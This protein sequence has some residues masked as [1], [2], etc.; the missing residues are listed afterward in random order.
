MD[1]IAGIIA[2][3]ETSKYFL[4]FGGS[5]LE[6]TIVM[7]GT[8]VLWHMGAVDFWPAY[9]ALMLGDILSDTCWYVLG[10]FAARPFLDRWGYLVG[11]P[12]E[13]MARVEKRFTLYQTPILI[14]SKL[15]MG[16]GLMVATLITAGALRISFYKFAL[17]E[18][19][20]GLAWVLF[21]MVLGYYFGDFLTAFPI[22]WQIIIGASIFVL[23]FFGLKQL[24]KTFVEAD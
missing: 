12:P 22:Q 1:T 24:S 20:G 10:Y 9:G 14:I 23:V 2:F 6:G 16:F 17:I 19:V 3:A 21:L 18:F 13:T 11:A 7:I 8:G 4:I 15:T 5:F